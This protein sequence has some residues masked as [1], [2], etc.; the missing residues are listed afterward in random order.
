MLFFV[1]VFKH[2]VPFA[3]CRPQLLSSGLIIKSMAVNASKYSQRL[4]STQ[5]RK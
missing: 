1:L 2:G 5:D 3:I 4:A